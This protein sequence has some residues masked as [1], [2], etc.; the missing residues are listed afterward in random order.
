MDACF[1]YS[2]WSEGEL[3]RAETTAEEFLIRNREKIST[4]FSR[5]QHALGHLLQVLDTPDLTFEERLDCFARI[6]EMADCLREC[7]NGFFELGAQPM[8]ARVIQFPEAELE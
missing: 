3:V 7:A 5:Q 6:S 1:D 8:V 4:I 2:Q